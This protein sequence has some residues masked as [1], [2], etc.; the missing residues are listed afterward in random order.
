[1]ADGKKSFVL[2]TEIIHTVRKLSNEKAGELFKHILAYVN[3]EQPEANDIL[4]EIAFE[5]IKQALK[6][7]L[8]KWEETSSKKATSGSIGGL[9]SGEAR[10][11]KA[12]QA[13]AI[14]TKNEA[15]E[16]NASNL[17]QNE[18]V[19]VYVNDNVNV[20]VF[21]E[22]DVKEIPPPVFN[23]D[24]LIQIEELE[25]ILLGDYMWVESLARH[26]QFDMT[27][28]EKSIR[29]AKYWI[30]MYVE[31]QKAE[32]VKIKSKQDAFSHCKRWI[33]TQLKNG[34]TT[35]KNFNGNGTTGTGTGNTENLAAKRPIRSAI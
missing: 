6:K 5:P 21:K 15:N 26:F 9:K 12:E 17:K 18:H 25:A 2:Y 19:N 11:A 4:I 27:N 28:S 23:S 29:I 10:R 20:N 14:A 1:M 16:A 7:D 13:K 3:D 34:K 8:I 35:T 32:N 24:H 31:E 33:N 30:V 22:G